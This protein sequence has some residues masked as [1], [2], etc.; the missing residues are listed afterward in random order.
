[1]GESGWD[2][3]RVGEERVRGVGSGRDRVRRVRGWG[4]E[5]VR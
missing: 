5:W 1:M 2:E 3:G 4:R